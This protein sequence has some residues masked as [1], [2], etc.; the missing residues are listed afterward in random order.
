MPKINNS[1]LNS[2]GYFL[3]GKIFKLTDQPIRLSNIADPVEDK[4]AVNLQTLRS[5]S[6]LQNSLIIKGDGNSLDSPQDGDYRITV[7]SGGD[8]VIQY[9]ISNAWDTDNETGIATPS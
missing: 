5:L 2:L 3:T 9:R 4:E 8:L 6:A 7:N 1:L